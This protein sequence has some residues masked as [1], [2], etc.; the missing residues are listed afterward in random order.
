MI[1]DLDKNEVISTLFVQGK[2]YRIGEL[3]KYQK[4]KIFRLIH[5]G[6]SE[7]EL[8]KKRKKI[9]PEVLERLNKDLDV[10]KWETNDIATFINIITSKIND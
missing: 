9:I 7:E 2:E 1:I 5:W 10:S 4:N 6:W 8:F 3:T